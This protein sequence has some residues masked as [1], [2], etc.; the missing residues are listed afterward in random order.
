MADAIRKRYSL[1]LPLFLIGDIESVKLE[2]KPY[3]QPFEQVL[4]HQELRAL[5][6]RN[7]EVTEQF[8]YFVVKTSTPVS[9]LRTRL[10][11]WQRIGTVNLEPTVQKTL[12]FTQNGTAG[13]DRKELHNARRLR[14]GP[15]DLHEYRGKF[16]P[17]LVRSLINISGASDEAVVL[18]PMCGSGTTPCEALVAGRPTIAADLNPLSVLIATVKAAVVL[19]NP[20][21]FNDTVTKH[22]RAFQ[23]ADGE[24]NKPEWSEEDDLYLRRWFDPHALQEIGTILHDI[25]LVK[26]PL[27][28]NLYLICLSNILRSVS[29]QKET[30][31]RVRKQ[32][33]P[34]QKGKALEAFT[35]EVQGQLDRIY[36]YL[37][38]LPKRTTNPS[39]LVKQGNA[40]N[41]AGLFPEYSGKVEVLITS[42]PYATALPYLDTDRLSLIVLGLLPRKQHR[43]FEN[44]M[45]GTR[46]VSER[47][48]AVAWTMFEQRREDLPA[49]V[50][51]LIDDIAHHNHGPNIGFR[52]RNLPAL[53][54][55]Y[56]LDMLDAMRSARALMAPGSHGYYVV[57]NNSTVLDGTKIE[58]PT[59]KFLFELGARAGWKQVEMLPMELLA[60]RDIFRE[61][62][63]SA[64][65][66]LCF[67]T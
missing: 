50:T 56:Y 52:R 13:Y 40:V 33:T 22:L 36:T 43:K 53:L 54:G 7:D 42:P 20:D 29:W 59:D 11:Y 58:I 44:H 64:E 35:K 65:T 39:M 67:G 66:I 5:I 10:T 23:S 19:E 12:E 17:Q 14:Y 3:L 45:I 61:N 37:T 34:Y 4:A 55:R 24:G 21:A 1:P 60:S 48:R 25:R 16:F 57:G 6:G 32:I 28:R 9:L 62:R 38:V 46:E 15:H 8:G 18:D 2:L 41:V 63:G 30:D 26:M 49:C 51:D 47:E 27:Y 31:L